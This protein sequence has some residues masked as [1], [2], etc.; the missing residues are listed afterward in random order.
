M[1][2]ELKRIVERYHQHKKYMKEYNQ[3]PEVKA[4]KANKRQLEREAL[5]V[6]RERGLLK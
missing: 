3:R 1:D 4:R 5:K 2:E 6:A